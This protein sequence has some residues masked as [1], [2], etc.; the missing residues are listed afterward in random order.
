MAGISSASTSRGARE[1]S[2]GRC[3]PLSADIHRGHGVQRPDRRLAG[4][5]GEGERAAAQARPTSVARIIRRRS[6]VS[7]SAPPRKAVTS[8][9]SSSARPE[10]PHLQR[11]AGELEHLVGQGDVGHHRAEERH[12]LR[13][14]QRPEVAVAPERSQVHGW[15]DDN[16][17]ALAMTR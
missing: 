14:E 5:R 13:G 12:E 3:R 7:A 8:S 9:G 10:Q 11:G 6:T 1:S 2:E 16:T 15:M 4:E 17:G